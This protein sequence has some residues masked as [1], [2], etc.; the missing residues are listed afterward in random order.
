MKL[1]RA[2]EILVNG[3]SLDIDRIYAGDFLDENGDD[4]SS[5]RYPY[6][7]PE[8]SFFLISDN[9]DEVN[10]SR[11]TGAF[12]TERIDGKVISILRTRGL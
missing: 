9:R 8:N 1:V 10:D 11:A 6:T 2:G 4:K 12:E 7:V 3:M 5:I